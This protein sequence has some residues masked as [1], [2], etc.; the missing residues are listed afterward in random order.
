[1]FY[2]PY[3]QVFICTSISYFSSFRFE[4]SSCF[5]A[6]VNGVGSYLFVCFGAVLLNIIANVLQLK[7]TWDLLE[8]IYVVAVDVVILL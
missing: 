7:G 8:L 3:F 4:W 1:M 2:L 5:S 6:S